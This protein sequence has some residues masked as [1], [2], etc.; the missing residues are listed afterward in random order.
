MAIHTHLIDK[1]K[2]KEFLKEERKDPFTQQRIEPGDRIVF[3]AN[4]KLAFSVTTWETIKDARYCFGSNKCDH[5]QTLREFPQAHKVIFKSKRKSTDSN[6]SPNPPTPFPTR[7]IFASLFAL[8]IIVGL[9]I[10]TPQKQTCTPN[11]QA[12]QQ[13]IHH[14]V[15]K[16]FSV[17]KQKDIGSILSYYDQKVNYLNKG[18]VDKKHIRKDKADYFDKWTK[19]EQHLQGDTEILKSSTP[20]KTDIKFQFQFSA[21]NQ[22]RKPGAKAISGMT[23]QTW[24]LGCVE[25]ELKNTSENKTIIKWVADEPVHLK[26][27]RI[28]TGAGVKLRKAPRWNAKTVTI[29]QIG[30]IVSQLEPA[31]KNWYRVITPNNKKGWVHSKYAMSFDINQFEQ[32]YLVVAN[33]KLNS[34]ASFG[35]LVDLYHFLARVSNEVTQIKIAAELKLLHLLALQRSLEKIPRYQQNNSPY[36]EWLKQRQAKIEY[37]NSTGFGSVKRELFQQLHE[38]YS[39]LPIAER[40]LREAP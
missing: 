37:N 36:S 32:T 11:K 6:R 1:G 10:A 5:T 33:K 31:R 26:Q 8:I 28:L 20:K 38:E 17:T 9:I 3:C 35:D 2:H 14:F 23:V 7:K 39:G 30:T 40:I 19:I 27:V 24:T 18:L 15:E 16:Y 21:R 4:C 13:E 12:T 25:K 29:L 22:N 34:K